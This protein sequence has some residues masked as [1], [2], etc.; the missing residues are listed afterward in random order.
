MA[1]IDRFTRWPEV[2]PTTDITT[3]ANCK[4]LIHNWIP[5][6]GCPVTITIDQGRNFDS[7]V[8]RHLNDIL[9]TERIRTTSHTHR[10]M[11]TDLKAVG[12]IPLIMYSEQLELAQVPT[13][14]K[15]RSAF[16]NCH[17]VSPTSSAAGGPSDRCKPTAACTHIDF[18]R[19]IS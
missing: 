9:G 12:N 14:T 18:F 11:F 7:Y 4:S 17:C 10:F 8:F 5:R 19:P 15:N 2:I 13:P 6:F 1:I 3:E 16:E